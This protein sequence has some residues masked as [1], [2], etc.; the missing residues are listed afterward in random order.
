MSEVEPLNTWPSERL[1]TIK[2]VTFRNLENT[3]RSNHVFIDLKSHTHT[4]SY[5]HTCVQKHIHTDA[6]T[7]ICTLTHN[8]TYTLTDKDIHTD[9]YT[10]KETHR[11]EKKSKLRIITD[12]LKMEQ[13][14]IYQCRDIK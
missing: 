11:H 7:H 14:H 1:P 10:H 2:T 6:H 9:K 13:E 3:Q 4:Y 8:H 12:N 5:S